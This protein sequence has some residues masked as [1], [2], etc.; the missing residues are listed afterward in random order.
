M[1]S[2]ITSCNRI[3]LLNQTLKS[4]FEGQSQ[5]L[6]ITIHEDGLSKIG[7]HKSIEKFLKNNPKEKYFLHCEEDWSFDNSY[8]WIKASIDI[9]ENDRTIIKVL[10]RKD[11]VHPCEY[12]KECNGDKYGILEPWT[13]EWKGITWHGF[14]FNPGVTRL[15]LLKEFI[16]FPKWEQELSALI[17]AKG[18]RTAAL[19]KAVYH[20]IGQDQSTHE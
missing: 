4:L 12:N 18:Y 15:D 13:D 17:Y 1:E 20:H 9:M 11:M 8:D 19:E 7:Q 3:D 5:K 16:P 14:G 10:A 2:L 6:L